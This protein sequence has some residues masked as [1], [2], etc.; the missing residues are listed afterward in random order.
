MDLGTGFIGHDQNYQEYVQQ[1]PSSG[2][3]PTNLFPTPVYN[4]SNNLIDISAKHQLQYKT[5]VNFYFYSPLIS[6]SIRFRFRQIIR[7]FKVIFISPLRL[8]LFSFDM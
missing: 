2:A 4:P 3:D 6:T 5:D 7:Y 8:K 1:F